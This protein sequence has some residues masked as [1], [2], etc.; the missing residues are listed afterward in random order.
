MIELP[1]IS[2]RL[3]RKT[4]L[5]GLAI[6]LL[7]INL[8]RWVVGYYSDRREELVAQSA[9]LQQ[10]DI[11]KESLPALKNTV[12]KLEKRYEQLAVFLFQG[13]SEEEISSA[14][15]IIL[16][17]HVIKAGLEPEFIRPVKTG[18]LA[19]GETVGEI[20]IKVRLS[21]KMENFMNFLSYL[22]NSKNLF[23]IED[24]SLKPFK[25]DELK[26]VMEIKGF[27]RAV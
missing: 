22:Y 4:I 27:Y 16:Q 10:Q 25:E 21:G 17:E 15:Q 9:L 6:A 12:A 7:V 11:T 13:N 1:K 2:V 26:I 3:Q 24:V 5:I 18:A 23:K 8:G 20:A 19:K 14:M